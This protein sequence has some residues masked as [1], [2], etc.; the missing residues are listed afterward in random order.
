MPNNIRHLKQTNRNSNNCKNNRVII[1]DNITTSK[2]IMTKKTTRRRKIGTLRMCAKKTWRA[3]LP[4][5]ADACG[6]F[7]SPV[8]AV[9]LTSRAE[10]AVADNFHT[11]TSLSAHQR[12]CQ[13]RRS[14]S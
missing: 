11:L 14:A 8:F 12:N 2:K 10:V 9:M 5:F 7:F 4:N 13:G 6:N 1:S 3:T